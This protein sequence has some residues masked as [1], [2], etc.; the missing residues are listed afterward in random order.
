MTTLTPHT[1][2]PLTA[3]QIAK[4]FVALTMAAKTSGLGE[5][6]VFAADAGHLHAINFRNGGRAPR[7]QDCPVFQ[8]AT[9]SAGSAGEFNAIAKAWK[10]SFD[11]ASA[12]LWNA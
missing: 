2:R 9:E 10:A 11:T 5:K 1:R 8:A 7:I 4:Q 3:A 6:L 12:Q